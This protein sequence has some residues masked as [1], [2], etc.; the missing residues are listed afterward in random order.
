[1]LRVLAP[2][3]CLQCISSKDTVLNWVCQELFIVTAL[4]GALD[5]YINSENAAVVQLFQG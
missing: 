4:A 2:W 3:I 5:G 1:M